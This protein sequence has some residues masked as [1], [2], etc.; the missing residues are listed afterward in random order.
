[1][2]GLSEVR[3]LEDMCIDATEDYCKP[4]TPCFSREF[5]LKSY[6]QRCFDCLVWLL[7]MTLSYYLA[8]PQVLDSKMA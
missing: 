8:L 7:C 2:H 3:A 5:R 4:P 6:L 1:M